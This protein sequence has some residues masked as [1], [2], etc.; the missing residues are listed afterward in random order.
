[1]GKM[2]EKSEERNEELAEENVKLKK[3]MQE[4]ENQVVAEITDRMKLDE[5][6]KE[7]ETIQKGEDVINF[8]R[9]E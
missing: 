9:L 2:L 5:S 1:M 3:R 6:I 8:E 7:K 4:L